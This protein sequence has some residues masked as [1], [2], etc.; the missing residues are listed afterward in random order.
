MWGA[1]LCC[2]SRRP[3]REV[4][5]ERGCRAYV[6]KASTHCAEVTAAG[7]ALSGQAR[8]P[9]GAPY[10]GAQRGCEGGQARTPCGAPHFVAQVAGRCA[11]SEWSG[12]AGHT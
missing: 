2:P 6:G 7:V 3:V 5:M 1:A 8:A 4:R 9:G 11:K 10:F 12:V